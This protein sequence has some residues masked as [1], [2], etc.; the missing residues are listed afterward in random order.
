MILDALKYLAELGARTAAP[1]QIQT[2]DPATLTYLVGGSL[3]SVPRPVPSRGHVAGDV[4][5][6][7]S[8]ANRWASDEPAVWIDECNVYLVIDDA[9]GHR[10]NTATMV[11]KKSDVFK[12]LERLAASPEWLDQKA[13]LRLLRVDLAGTLPPG[14]LLDRVRKLRFESGQVTTQEAVRNRESMGRQITAAASGDGEI[15]EQVAL[16]LSVF[17][18]TPELAVTCAVDVDPGRGLLQLMPLPDELERVT[19]IALNGLRKFI[20]G[21]VDEGVKVYLGRP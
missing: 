11:L 21:A 8:M 10:V 1:T 19:E 15:P 3:V 14:I 6:L 18:D 4:G 7:V 20:A 17:S 16:E 9:E 2:G 12:R 5:T 13:F